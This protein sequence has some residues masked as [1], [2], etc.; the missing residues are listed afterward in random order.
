MVTNGLV[1]KRSDNL[2]KMCHYKLIVRSRFLLRG[3][4][5]KLGNEQQRIVRDSN[6][7]NK[8]FSFISFVS[9][10]WTSLSWWI[11][12]Q[13]NPETPPKKVQIFDN[14]NVLLANWNQIWFELSCGSRNE[15]FPV[16]RNWA[17]VPWQRTQTRKVNR[18]LSHV[19]VSSCWCLML[20]Q[21]KMKVIY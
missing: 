14:Y 3:C 7:I 13:W 16:Y 8:L 5:S 17:D 2:P 19:D 20:K 10:L 9:I 18:V 21:N 12:I 11:L 15:D 4:K 1:S 6:G